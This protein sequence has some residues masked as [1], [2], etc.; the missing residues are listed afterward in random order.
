MF[1]GFVICSFAVLFSLSSI[2]SRHNWHHIPSP[3]LPSHHRSAVFK[4]VILAPLFHFHG[5]SRT[6]R[7][8]VRSVG[9]FPWRM[10]V[11]QREKMTRQR[12]SSAWGGCS[13]ALDPTTCPVIAQC[14]SPGGTVTVGL[15]APSL[16]RWSPTGNRCTLLGTSNVPPSAAGCDLMD[17]GVFC[18]NA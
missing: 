13:P 10:A 12:I 15:G 4:A 9:D 6:I 8:W 18:M 5:N 11:R 17:A 3:E 2:G 16:L 7:D 14:M 1:L